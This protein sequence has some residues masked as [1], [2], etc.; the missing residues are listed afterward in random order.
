[1]VKIR[2]AD[3]VSYYCV[4]KPTKALTGKSP[5]VFTIP[6]KKVWFFALT[7]YAISFLGSFIAAI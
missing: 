2:N 7:M 6:S 3:N 1:M 5:Y 4:L